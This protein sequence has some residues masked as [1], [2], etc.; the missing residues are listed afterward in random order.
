MDQELQT[1]YQGLAKQFN[2]SWPLNQEDQEFLDKIIDEVQYRTAQ[3]VYQ[4]LTDQQIEQFNQIN[5]EDPDGSIAYL[6]QVIPNY[7][8]LVVKSAFEV[9]NDLEAE[10]AILDKTQE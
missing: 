3:K 7:Q 5:E 2:M 4:L 10:V 6:E 8:D 9:R 1:I